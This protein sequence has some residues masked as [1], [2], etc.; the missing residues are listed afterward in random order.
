M[1][2]FERVYTYLVGAPGMG[3]MAAQRGSGWWEGGLGDLRDG[4]ERHRPSC[5]GSIYTVST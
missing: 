3:V 1:S 5:G 4:R 2:G